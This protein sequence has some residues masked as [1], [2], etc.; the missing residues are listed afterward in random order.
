MERISLPEQRV[1]YLEGVIAAACAA[2]DRGEYGQARRI[3]RTGSDS[4]VKSETGVLA[5]RI[6]SL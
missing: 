5:G 4:A 3:L 1:A 6:H 2:M